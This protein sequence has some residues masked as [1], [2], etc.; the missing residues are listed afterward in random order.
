[1][2]RFDTEERYDET[3]KS[4]IHS[5]SAKITLLAVFIVVVSLVGSMINASSKSSDVVETVNA[6]Y[7]L[8]LAEMGAQTIGNIPAEIATDEQFS[9]VVSDISMKG[10][11]SAYAYLVSA[12]GTMLYHPTADKIGKTVENPVIKGVVSQLASGTVPEDA[13]VEYDFNGAIKYAGYALTPDHMIVVVSADKS[14]IVEPVNEMIRSMCITAAITLVVC[15]II[16]YVLSRFICAPLESLTEIIKNTANLNFSHNAKS[17][18]L[19]KRTDETGFMAR[20]LRIMRKNLREMVANID[21]A[22]Q[23]ITGNVDGLKQVTETVDHMCSDNSATSQQLAAGMQETAATTVNINENVGT[24]KDEA[25]RLTEMAEK[26]ADVSNEIMDR[27]KN[28]RNKTVTAS[29]RTMDMYT[30]VKE[31][32][33]KA[34]EGSKAVEKINELTNTIMEISSQTGLL[35]LNASIEA[36]RAGEAGRGFAVVATEIGSLADQTSKAIADIG[37]IVKAVNE[38]VGNMTECL[39]ETTEFLET[40]VIEDYK[41]FEKVGEQYQEDADVFKSNMNQVKDSMLQLSDLIESIAQALSGINDT[42]G[43][44]AVGVSDIAEKTS[45][46]VEKTGATH[47]M[48]SECYSCADNLREIVGKF[49]LK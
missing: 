41:E 20:E 10:V 7:I 46:M 8:S 17:D 35:A 27:A 13:V 23:Q 22:S 12:D 38:A 39:G 31:K 29:S 49:V 45:G 3:G 24:M 43:E 5:I 9:R 18:G 48:V 14:D 16:G 21:T 30:S 4:Y 1:M 34:I 36:A 32:S 15:V 2:F 28:L 44:A 47:D 6:H 37:N 25:E 26:G 40:N 42:V 33:E 19:C 11:D